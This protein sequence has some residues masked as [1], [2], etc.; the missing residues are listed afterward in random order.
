[1][2]ITADVICLLDDDVFLP[3]HFFVSFPPVV[4]QPP[5]VCICTI[6]GLRYTKPPRWMQ[7]SPN[8]GL[9]VTNCTMCWNNVEDKYVETN[10]NKISSHHSL[11]GQEQQ[12]LTAVVSKSTAYH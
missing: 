6:L 7:I 11:H 3:K 1:M 8:I 12:W 4:E 9:I 2:H 10:S 5:N